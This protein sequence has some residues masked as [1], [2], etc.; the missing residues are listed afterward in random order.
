MKFIIF[1][2][3]SVFIAAISTKQ[4]CGITCPNGSNLDA[5]LCTCIPQ[6]APTCEISCPFGTTLVG[7]CK[8]VPQI[9][10][11]CKTSCPFGTT[12][13]APCDC[14][15][16]PYCEY[17]CRPGSQLVFPCKCLPNSICNIECPTGTFLSGCE[18]IP[19]QTC[20]ISSCPPGTRF[21]PAKCECT[22]MSIT[23]SLVSQ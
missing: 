5:D 22:R 13:V 16:P 17:Q 6:I 14:V 20:N 1:I 8:C 4:C 10:P 2:I 23:H 3:A 7:P 11:T 19:K 21:W 9:A 18:C 15:K 12:L